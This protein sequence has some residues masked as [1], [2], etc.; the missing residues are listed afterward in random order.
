M[1]K[2][3]PILPS[4]PDEELLKAVT[5]KP[6]STVDNN[7]AFQI[8]EKI[9]P[10]VSIPS[11]GLSDIND[12][13]FY[14]FNNVLEPYI[15]RDGNKIKVPI[16]YASSEL[17]NAVQKE[18]YWRDKNG[19]IICPFIILKRI[20]LEKIRSIGNK[21]DGNKVNNFVC[22][23]SRY[24]SK[25]QY[26]PMS[27]LNN[28]TPSEKIYTVPVPDYVKINYECVI[29]TNYREEN[30]KMLEA[31]EYV[32]DSYWGNKDSFMFRTFVDSMSNST[33]YGEDEER[34]AKSELSFSLYGYLL[35][36]NEV[37]DKATNGTKQYYSISNV[38]IT[39]ETNI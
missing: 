26:T 35:P 38:I 9:E 25:N 12:A 28:N 20:S 23:K 24:N 15:I 18:G 4:T 5:S 10:N 30:D 21:L 36:N 6:L 14:Y 2:K 34:I 3:L 19:K 16:I 11:I 22:F 8:S 31:I 29:V 1:A 17:W 27:V 39:S 7:R 37:R 33:E 13:V 32:S